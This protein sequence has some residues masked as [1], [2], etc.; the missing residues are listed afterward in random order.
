[1]SPKHFTGK[2]AYISGGSCEGENCNL[3]TKKI[4]SHKEFFYLGAKAMEYSP[5][6]TESQ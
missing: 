2:F 4:K 1:M 6:I 5:S 3:Y